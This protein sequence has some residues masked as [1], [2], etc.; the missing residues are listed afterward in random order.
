MAPNCILI[1]A[2]IFPNP[3]LECRASCTVFDQFA[4]PHHRFLL[5]ESHL[6][7]YVRNGGVREQI[8]S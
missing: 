5:D 2:Q 8:R 7:I 3:H 6:V 4:E 1:C